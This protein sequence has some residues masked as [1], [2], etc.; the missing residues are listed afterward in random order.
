MVEEVLVFTCPY[1]AWEFGAY[2][3]EGYPLVGELELIAVLEL[4]CESDEHEW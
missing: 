3:V 1:G 2:L 4:L